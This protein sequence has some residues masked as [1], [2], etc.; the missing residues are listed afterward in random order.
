MITSSIINKFQKI[1]NQL[2]FFNEKILVAVSG[3]ADSIALLRLLL[4]CKEHSKLIVVVIDHKM[5]LESSEEAHFVENLCN[6]YQINCIK[7]IWDEDN[8]N[9]NQETARR[10]RYA[11]LFRIAKDYFVSA[12]VTA[13]HKD[14]IIENFFIRANRGSGVDGLGLVQPVTYQQNVKLVKPLIFFYK[15]ELVKYLKSINQ[16]YC[17]DQSNFKPTYL[18]NRFRQM[19]N[20]SDDFNKHNLFTTCLNLTRNYL[21]KIETIAG[22]VHYVSSFYPFGL[23]EINS[24]KFINLTYENALSLLN[25]ILIYLGN[26]IQALRLNQ[27]INVLDKI[28][29]QQ[30]FKICLN[31]VIIQQK[32]KII[33]FYQE[34]TNYPKSIKAHAIYS[35]SFYTIKNYSLYNLIL[36][37]PSKNE[38]SQF[39]LNSK[40]KTRYA[41][42]LYQL[43]N[44]LPIYYISGLKNKY[45]APTLTNNEIIINWMPEQPL[46]SQL[47][48]LKDLKFFEELVITKKML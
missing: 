45:L 48:T 6:S 34:N 17:I 25:K 35:D 40:S 15:E 28:N 3:G 30:N 27:L 31:K 2:D 22:Q 23:V 5:R 41:H 29:N 26:N 7:I 12:I 46:I 42:K 13:H 32:N 10:F 37:A 19:L 24:E 33:S 36:R 4:E 38:Q 1:W 44:T 9:K 21:N 18:R 39:T 47:L 20:S 43:R 16:Q 11:Q 8:L 14:D